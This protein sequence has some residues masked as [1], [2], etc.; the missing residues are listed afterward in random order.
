MRISD[1]S[2]DVCSSD[3]A[4]GHEREALRAKC[5]RCKVGFPR[6][7][8]LL[9]IAQ[10]LPIERARCDVEVEGHIEADETAQQQRQPSQLRGGLGM[11]TSQAHRI[12]LSG[13]KTPVVLR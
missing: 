2:S 9:L 12:V 10:L 4:V 13:Q 6:A 8:P 11:Q 7:D 5:Q 3:L 1:W